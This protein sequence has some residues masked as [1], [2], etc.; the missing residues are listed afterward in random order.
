MRQLKGEPTDDM[1]FFG[2][3]HG[4]VKELRLFEVLLELGAANPLFDPVN[5][6]AVSVQLMS[7]DKT[8]ASKRHPHSL[9][10]SF[11]SGFIMSNLFG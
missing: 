10:A 1:F 7:I 8:N 6:L 9:Y 11:A 4:I 5:V 2:R 3:A